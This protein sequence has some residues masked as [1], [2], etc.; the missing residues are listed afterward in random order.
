M[1]SDHSDARPVRTH[2]VARGDLTLAMKAT[3]Q[4]ERDPPIHKARTFRFDAMRKA[5]DAARPDAVVSSRELHFSLTVQEDVTGN[6]VLGKRIGESSAL[7]GPSCSYTLNAFSGLAK[8]DAPRG[9][10]QGPRG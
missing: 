9:G 2:H 8:A 3:L 5:F 10:G 7:C 1:S 4:P 6:R